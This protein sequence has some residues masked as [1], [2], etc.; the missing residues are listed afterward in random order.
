MSFSWME[1]ESS[2]PVESTGVDLDATTAPK[3]T[4][5]NKESCLIGH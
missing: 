1:V 3:I 2:R 5:N 4:K